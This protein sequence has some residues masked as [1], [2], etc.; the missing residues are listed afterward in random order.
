MFHPA[1][2]AP[3]LVRR[4]HHVTMLSTA[5]ADGCEREHLS[6]NWEAHYIRGTPP[7][8]Y[9][10]EYFATSRSVFMRLHHQAPFD[11]VYSDSASAAGL[12]GRPPVPL[13]TVCHASRSMVINP[14]SR[15]FYDQWMTPLLRAS[16]AI[17]TE[18]ESVA[19]RIRADEPDVA[20]SVVVIPNGVD[21]QMFRPAVGEGRHNA[22]RC[23]GMAEGVSVLAF[24]GRAVPE[25]GLATVL[26]AVAR[27]NQCGLSAHG[28]LIG[29]GPEMTR[30][31]PFAQSRGIPATFIPGVPHGQLPALLAAADLYAFPTGHAEG[32]PFSLLEAMAAGLPVVSYDVGGVRIASATNRRVCWCQPAM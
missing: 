25:K 21:T 22:R 28:L 6:P 4:G 2:I 3:E 10:P 31:P 26:D 27:L 9:S 19:A 8:C 32:M 15:E 18:S 14:A 17:L 24:T 12:L 30:L 5:R 11:A 23:L 20:H 16:A 1:V 29:P 7:D 13:V